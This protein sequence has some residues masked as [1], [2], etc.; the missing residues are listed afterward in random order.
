MTD[1]DEIINVVK[2]IYEDI[3]A[4]AVMAELLENGISSEDFIVRPKGLFKR[5]YSRDIDRVDDCDLANYQKVMELYLNRDGLYDSL[6][7]GLFH[8]KT[9]NELDKE[10]KF[11][12][13]SVE[14][15]KEENEARLFFLPFENELFFQRVQLELEERNILSRFSEKIFNDIYPEL[16]NLH[17]SIN[18][19]YVYRMVLFLHLAHKIAGNLLLTAK[20]LEAVIGEKVEVERGSLTTNSSTSGTDVINSSPLGACK[21]GVNLVTGFQPGNRQFCIGFKIGPLTSIQP[22]EFLKDAPMSRFLEC[23]Y[24]YFVPVEFNVSTSIIVDTSK[25]NFELKEQESGPVLGYETA[26]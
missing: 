9:G 24:N 15:K 17:R 12:E 16:W 8:K 5:R 25:Q 10:R 6:P 23:F 4:E 26:I 3:R 1:H 21:L 19:E 22:K 2:T 14:L 18:R 7:Q 20:C 13:D 11:S